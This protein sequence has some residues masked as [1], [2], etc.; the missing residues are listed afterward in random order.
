[1]SMRGLARCRRS[2]SRSRERHERDRG[3]E[4]ERERFRERSVERRAAREWDRGR[5]RDAEGRAED[6][7]REAEPPAERKSRVLFVRNIP[8]QMTEQRLRDLF[9]RFGAVKKVFAQINQRG[10]AFVTFV[11]AQPR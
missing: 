5:E 10:I 2:R 7:G 6:R 9:E 11:A 8:F 3:R 4:R 1:M